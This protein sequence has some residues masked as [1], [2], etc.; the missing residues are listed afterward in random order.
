MKRTFA[1]FCVIVFSLFVSG[2]AFAYT[3]PPYPPSPQMKPPSFNPNPGYVPL[4]STPRYN[5]WYPPSWHPYPQGQCYPYCWY[6]R[7]RDDEAIKWM[8]GLMLFQIMLQQSNQ[9]QQ[10]QY[11]QQQITE[12]M[13][14]QQIQELINRV[15][16]E[17]KRQTE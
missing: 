11:Q 17:Y 2:M 14:Q 10:M 6:P 5:K 1:V 15:L 12:F 16:D 3:P 9:N 7:Y 8:V 13:R 4:P